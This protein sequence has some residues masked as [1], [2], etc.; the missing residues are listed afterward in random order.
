MS[1]FEEWDFLVEKAEK[2]ERYE[3][4]VYWEHH[5][6]INGQS[7]S[8]VETEYMFSESADDICKYLTENGIPVPEYVFAAVKRTFSG[9]LTEAI[10]QDYLRAEHFLA[11]LQNRSCHSDACYD[12]AGVEDLHSAICAFNSKNKGR[13]IYIPDFSRMVR[14]PPAPVEETDAH[15]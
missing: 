13:S 3:G 1:R 2:L 10:I 8:G 15:N 14:V 6:I 7:A 12:F 9:L 5:R 11:G 4:H